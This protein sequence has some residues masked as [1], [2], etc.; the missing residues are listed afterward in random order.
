M[1][2]Q[3]LKIFVVFTALVGLCA[4]FLNRVREPKLAA[5]GESW[6]CAFSTGEEQCGGQGECFITGKVAW[7]YCG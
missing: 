7:L 1:N 6:Q 4:V 2:K 5:R 3:A